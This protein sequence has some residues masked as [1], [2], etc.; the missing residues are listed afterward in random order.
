MASRVTSFAIRYVEMCGISGPNEASTARNLAL[1]FI[2]GLERIMSE[3]CRSR[4]GLPNIGGS[5]L[6]VSTESAE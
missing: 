6:W 2:L 3:L 1:G 5:P 4:T